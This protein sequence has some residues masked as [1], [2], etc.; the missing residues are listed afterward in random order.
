MEKGIYN[1]I[2]ETPND[3]YPSKVDQWKYPSADT[4]HEHLENVT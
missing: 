3:P 4:V 2:L 1:G